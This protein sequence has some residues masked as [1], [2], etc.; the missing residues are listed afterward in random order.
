M[1]IP[2]NTPLG[3]IGFL[4]LGLGVFLLLAGFSILNVEKVTVKPGRSTWVIGLIF[5]VAG[6][7]LVFLGAPDK[8][9]GASITPVPM[10]ATISI[11]TSSS[12][13]ETPTLVPGIEPSATSS[14][15]SK[16]SALLAEA[17]AWPIT[18]M[19]AFDEPDTAW[20][21]Y[22]TSGNQW[23]KHS[24]RTEEGKLFWGVE[25]L[26]PNQWYWQVSPYFS[27]RDFYLSCKFKRDPAGGNF[28]SY[29][30][31]F[32]KQGDKL[33]LFRIDENQRFSV[34]LFDYE[35]WT[36]LIGWTKSAEIRPGEFNEL[37]VIADGPQMTFYIN[38]VFVGNVS[39][40]AS[41]NGEVG[42]AVAVNES[43]PE[44]VFEFDDFEL[45]EKP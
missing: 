3:F 45:R 16:E 37:T 19:E 24:Q 15:F 8:D 17:S 4:M 41:D 25:L 1:Q 13:A 38:K 35:N 26:S 43:G 28:T 10:T 33:Y 29:G 21:P 7:S 11:A 31:M 42:F 18:E 30:L 32:R 6:I 20:V 40:E 39:D 27:Y 2:F 14:E 22:G 44:V 5:S 23:V 9:P 12:A 34:Q 36:D